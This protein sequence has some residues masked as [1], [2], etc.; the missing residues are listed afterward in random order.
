M[1]EAIEQ[2]DAKETKAAKAD[3]WHAIEAMLAPVKRIDIS[4]IGFIN[5]VPDHDF[6]KSI[7]KSN[8]A[9][10]P[11]VVVRQGDKLRVIEGKRRVAAHRLLAAGENGKIFQKID[12]R[13]Y[14]DD[15][16]SERDRAILLIRLNH[17][18]SLNPVAELKAINEI[19]RHG[20]TDTKKIA[21]L[22]GLG[23]RQ[24]Q[25]I[26]QIDKLDPKLQKVLSDGRMTFDTAIRAARLSPAT[27]RKLIK[28]ADEKAGDDN[29]NGPGQISGAD[30]HALIERGPA[31]GLDKLFGDTVTVTPASRMSTVLSEVDKL[32]ATLD[33][34]EKK[35]LA[36]ARKLLVSV[37]L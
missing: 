20:T 19:R 23:Q 12:A 27:Q 18:R 3:G 34:D 33:G 13:V 36:S 37:K 10:E 21:R 9:V 24:V 26:M 1:T 14:E 2:T 16:L 7:A 17:H 22:V 5:V 8:G 31:K 29:G 35:V 30:I 11:I 25:R 4:E 32:I 15:Q 28:I 6:V